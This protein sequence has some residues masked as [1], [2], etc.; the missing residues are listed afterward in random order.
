LSVDD[1]DG[2]TK[3]FG[4]N[5]SVVIGG[6]WSEETKDDLVHAW[7]WALWLH[8]DPESREEAQSAIGSNQVWVVEED[9][10]VSETSVEG[11]V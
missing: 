4:A 6:T 8:V 3:A 7:L 5:V 11:D 10:S 1:V 9:V 2:G